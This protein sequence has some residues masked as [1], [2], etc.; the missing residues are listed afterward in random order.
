MVDPLYDLTVKTVAGQ[1]LYGRFKYVK[2]HYSLLS[3]MSDSERAEILIALH[4]IEDRLQEIADILRVVNKEN[5]EAAQ[6]R[7][8]SGSPLRVRIMELCDGNKSV[9]D[10]AKTLGKAIQQVSNNI[11]TLQNV[12][13]V[14]EARKGKEKRYLK[15]R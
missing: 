11:T 6:D 14:K 13:L 10:I 8:L 4:N 9:T 7:V 3:N 5:I 1:S 15:T 2:A 12:G